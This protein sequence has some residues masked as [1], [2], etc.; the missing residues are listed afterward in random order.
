[1]DMEDIERMYKASVIR[2]GLDESFREKVHEMMLLM[3]SIPTSMFP[4]EMK[5][6]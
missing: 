5:F 4:S 1:M 6:A 3:Q 2:Y